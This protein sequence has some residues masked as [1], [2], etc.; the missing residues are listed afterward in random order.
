VILAGG[1]A[2]DAHLWWVLPS[3]PGVHAETGPSQVQILPARPNCHHAKLNL[4]FY[5]K[6]LPGFAFRK[7]WVCHLSAELAAVT[8]AVE[9]FLR[10][11]KKAYIGISLTCSTSV[12]Y[13]VLHMCLPYRGL[14]A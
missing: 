5:E 1:D 4:R 9:R 13:K 2:V 11:E 7:V 3:L 6:M 10:V 14:K 8:S 12:K